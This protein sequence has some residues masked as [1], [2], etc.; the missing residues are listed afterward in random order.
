MPGQDP[1][2]YDVSET[3]EPLRIQIPADSVFGS[4]NLDRGLPEMY[5]ADLK[6][7]IDED[8]RHGGT[9]RQAV[10]YLHQKFSFPMAC[11]VFG[12]IGLALGLHTR[13]EGKLAGLTLGLI[14]I[15]VYYGL[16]ELAEGLV[17]GDHFPPV[18]ARWFP[19]IV[20]GALGIWLLWRRER[21]SGAALTI[22]IGL[23]RLTQLLTRPRRRTAD[24]D[25]PGPPPRVVLVIRVPEFTLPRPRLLDLYVSTQYLRVAALAFLAF[26]GLYYIGTVIDLS[27]KVLKGQATMGMVAQYLWYS[28]P[29]FVI[30]VVPTATLVAVLATIGGL[31][32]SSEL[33]VMRA[34]G[35]S[36]YRAAIPLLALALLWSG[37]LFLVQE[38]VLPDAKRKADTLNDLIR[39]RA[40]HTVDVDNRHWYAASNGRMYYY[41]AYEPRRATFYDVSVFETATSPYRLASHTFAT[42]AAFRRG[43]T[44]QADKGW[45]QRFRKTPSGSHE[46]F[47]ARAITLGEPGDFSAAQ[48]ETEM[49]T[50]GQLRDYISRLSGTGLSL[51]EQRV[52]LQKKIALPLVT[53]VMTLL[54]VPFGVTTGRRGALYGIGLALVLAVGYWLL[55]TVFVA[56]G[57]AAVLPAALAAWAANILFLAGAAYLILT[58][59]T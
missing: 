1:T 6:K 50:F 33:T 27:E 43:Q 19:N 22:P 10:M 41:L 57:A 46:A 25:T 37:V 38:R 35:V 36:L 40:P 16:L 3:S 26:L 14:V 7:L 29:Q 2:V 56:M 11:L 20:L 13:K 44:W 59:R 53:L 52:G 5:I 34:C 31:T 15:F 32:R 55:L 21:S 54:G 24:G 42:R 18:W 51:S 45:V 9:A 17:K 12:M 28:T 8:R 47:T 49:M 48:V 30:F 4:G 58:V 39:G 23:D